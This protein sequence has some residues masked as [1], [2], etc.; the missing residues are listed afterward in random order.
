MKNK[1]S[2][3]VISILL[4]VVGLY[5]LFK[6]SIW[7]IYSS[8]L[9][10]IGDINETIYGYKNSEDISIYKKEYNDRLE[11]NQLSVGNYFKD[12]KYDAD[13]S[14]EFAETYYQYDGDKK[15]GM[16]SVG[17]F[18]SLVE[19]SETDEITFMY[20]IG[21][22]PRI[23]F[24]QLFYTGFNNFIKEKKIKDDADLV[25]EFSKYDFDNKLGVFTS[26]SK[27]R[28]DYSIR[29]V[30]SITLPVV[31]KIYYINGDFKGY[32]IEIINEEK[33]KTCFEVNLFKNNKRY[34]LS[35]LSKDY[36]LDDMKEIIS[37]IKL[38]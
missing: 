26:L 24:G 27:L 19:A 23:D 15:V 13:A 7:G 38:K 11:Y 9:N 14:T 1:K 36:D 12:F 10:D 30:A 33:E 5:I 21:D 16:F 8:L 34:I 25:K 4:L 2:F 35:V 29:L 17:T 31:D 32:M 28:E 18:H 20:S 22:E 37:T 3:I 6:A